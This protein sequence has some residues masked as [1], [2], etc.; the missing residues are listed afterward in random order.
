LTQVAYTRQK[1][2]WKR[3]KTCLLR[4]RGQYFIDLWLR[5][6]DFDEAEACSHST[7]DER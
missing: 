1:M 3:F 4:F 7:N 2:S 6:L 5:G